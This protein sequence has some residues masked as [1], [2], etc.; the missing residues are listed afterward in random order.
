MNG[1]FL[2][3]A[4]VSAGS[5]KL[6]EGIMNFLCIGLVVYVAILLLIGWLSGRKISGIDDYLVAGRR[7]PL[8]MATATLLATW[9]GAG[10]SMGVAAMTYSSG[11]KG[12][13]A[14]PFGASASLLLAGIFIVG[15]L[16]K[17]KCL[18]VTDII[19]RRYGSGAGI[20]ASL[21][22][23]PVYIG[24]LGSQI[25][26][27]GT[28]IHM[29]CGL[30]I[31]IGTI[32]GAAVV[33]A[34][35]CT[36]GMWAVTLTDLFQISLIVTGLLLIL[37]GALG[38]AGGFE[39]L[40]TSLS[41]ADLSL[42]VAASPGG[43]ASLND[44]TYFIGS[45]LV[46][47]LG[48]MVGQDLIQR[49]LAAKDE[50][51]A[52]SSSVISAFLY[53]G[54]AMIPVTIG[55]AAR[56]VLPK[57]GITAESMG[58]DLD[59]Q[60][61]PQMA[62]IVLSKFH[63]VILMLF[64][65][66]LFSAIMSSADSCLLAG[67]SLFCNNVLKPFLPGVSDRTFLLITRITTVVLTGVSLFLALSV[68]NIYLLMKNSWVAQLVVVF[69]PVITAIYL[70]R[71]SRNAAWAAMIV[72]TAVWLGYCFVSCIGTAQ[73]FGE[74][75]NSFD[76]PLTCGAVY[77]FAAG[78]AAFICCWLGERIAERYSAGSDSHER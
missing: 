78:I 12:I 59:N 32:I 71:V 40:W 20:Y 50:K 19:S 5:F 42:G 14:D 52:I 23:M 48:C 27:I 35:T 4:A 61:L 63:P 37:P 10:S 77:G 43:T 36:G 60:V 56:I 45:W 65:S 54:I 57:Y 25:L 28:L 2:S 66:A 41:K 53:F 33:L 76:R 70:P 1:F 55:F 11:L 39:R 75:M 29:L 21:W 58:G 31:W 3:A 38:E 44:W 9:F 30:E 13:I 73:S 47:G 74:L 72:S 15:M 62:M 16:R 34:Y 49:S 26:G 68:Q 64:L 51:V 67:T 69:T 18:T 6:P 17:L 22:M 46:M 8:W 7:L 24:W